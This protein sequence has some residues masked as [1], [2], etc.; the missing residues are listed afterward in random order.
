MEFAI[1]LAIVVLFEIAVLRWGKDSTYGLKDPE[2]DRR[3]VWRG[4]RRTW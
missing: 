1:I 2:W 4:F 3:R